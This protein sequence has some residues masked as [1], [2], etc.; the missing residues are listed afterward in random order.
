MTRVANAARLRRH[1]DE[2][3]VV[4]PGAGVPPIEG[5]ETIVGLAA[6]ARADRIFRVEFVDVQVTTTGQPA[7]FAR[8]SLTGRVTGSAPGGGRFVDG[9]ELELT[10][11]RLT[12]EW[13]ISRIRTVEAIRAPGR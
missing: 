3:I 7:G 8:V 10:M 1:F 9:R 4:E 12:G 5:R 11:S 2:R 6:R 13:L